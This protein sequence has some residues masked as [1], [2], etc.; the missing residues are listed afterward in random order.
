MGYKENLDPGAKQLLRYF[1]FAHLKPELQD[2]SKP[3]RAMAE[4][5]IETLPPSAE[6]TAALRK[7]LETKDCAVR[8][9]LPADDSDDA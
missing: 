6:R 1:K 9:G 4:W 3:F 5:L 7:L 2:K 8:A